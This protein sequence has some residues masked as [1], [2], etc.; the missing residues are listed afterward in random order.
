[1]KWT[2]HLCEHCIETIRSRGEIVWTDEEWDE[3]KCDW[4]DDEDDVVTDAVFE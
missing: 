1:M 4:C 2:M 3:G